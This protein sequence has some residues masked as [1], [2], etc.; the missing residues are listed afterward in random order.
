M[1]EDG[2]MLLFD[3]RN[4]DPLSYNALGGFIQ[5]E[6]SNDKFVYFH[7]SETTGLNPKKERIIEIGALQGGGGE[8]LETFHTLVNPTVLCR[9]RIQELTGI[10]DAMLYSLPDTAQVI[11]KLLDFVRSFLFWGTRFYLTVCLY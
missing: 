4:R 6:K 11:P 8:V 2:R 10:T 9:P 3:Y 7:R 5:G 1:L